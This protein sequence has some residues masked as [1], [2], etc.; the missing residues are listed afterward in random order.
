VITVNCGGINYLSNPSGFL[1]STVPRIY[2]PFNYCKVWHPKLYLKIWYTSK[3]SSSFSLVK[4]WPN[5]LELANPGKVLH[6]R[7]QWFLG[8]CGN[9]LQATGLWNPDGILRKLLLLLLE[10]GGSFSLIYYTLA[11][12]HS[13]LKIVPGK[14]TWRWREF[15]IAMLVYR[16]VSFCTEVMLECKDSNP[17]RTFH[18][19]HLKRKSC[20]KKMNEKERQ[21]K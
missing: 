5:K 18:T 3:L 21:I 15:Y 8:D 7:G 9:C 12:E 6:G 16:S 11:N 13:H 1:S 4:S 2:F 17:F 19:I 14:K 10:I 20:L